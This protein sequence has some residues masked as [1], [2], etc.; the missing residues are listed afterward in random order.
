MI[1]VQGPTPGRGLFESPTSGTTLAVAANG[2]GETLMKKN[3]MRFLT[4]GSLHKERS[5]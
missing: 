3:S 2:Q 5:K 4:Q 1:E